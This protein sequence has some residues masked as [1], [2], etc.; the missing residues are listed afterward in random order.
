MSGI[1]KCAHGKRPAHHCWG[2]EKETR[3]EGFKAGLEAAATLALMKDWEH[4]ESLARAI[5]KL[6]A[7]VSP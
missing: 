7:Q 5:R 6:A 1:P 4:L 2:C 3:A